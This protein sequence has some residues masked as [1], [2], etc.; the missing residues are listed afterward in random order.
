MTA[1]AVVRAVFALLVLAAAVSRLLADPQSEIDMR[2]VVSGMLARQG[3]EPRLS[4]QGPGNALASVDIDIAQC[5]GT[6]KI[7]PL[8][9]TVA[10]EPWL[11]EVLDPKAAKRFVYLEGTWHDVNRI[12]MRLEWLRHRVPAMLGMSRYIAHPWALL[13]VGPPGCN[14]A[15]IVD[16]RMMWDRRALAQHRLSPG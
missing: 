8:E 9:L 15:E 7:V 2:A 13:L 12:G 16:W 4:T 11:S 14:V 3:F 5:A 6:L 1:V 10:E